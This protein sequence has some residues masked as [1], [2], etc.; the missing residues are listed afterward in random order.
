MTTNRAYVSLTAVLILLSTIF[1]ESASL[2]AQSNPR[3]AATS[4][5]SGQAVVATDQS[6]RPSQPEA[7]F[8]VEVDMV[9]LNIAVTDSKGNYVVGLKPWDFTIQEDGVPQKIATFGEGNE[10]P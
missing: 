4:Q 1:S 10:A 3:P 6:Q 7:V 9:L 5:S 8:R 2:R